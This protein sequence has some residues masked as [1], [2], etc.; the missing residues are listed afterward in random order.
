MNTSHSLAQNVL[1]ELY[2]SV[3]SARYSTSRIR[4]GIQI[5]LFMDENFPIT[6]IQNVF[7]LRKTDA[8][9]ISCVIIWLRHFRIAR[10]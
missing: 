5:M 1:D 7:Y 9:L 10:H 4:Q 6:A 3:S 8:C 2:I